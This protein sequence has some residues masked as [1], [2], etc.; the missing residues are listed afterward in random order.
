MNHATKAM[1]DLYGNPLN[2]LVK[3]G[4]RLS[5]SKN[6]LGVRPSNPN[7]QN[8]NQRQQPQPPS[9][10]HQSQVTVSS[11][12]MNFS[13]M[14]DAFQNRAPPSDI[15]IGGNRPILRH[16]DSS[17]AVG[18]TELN[19][20]NHIYSYSISPPPTSRFFSPPPPSSLNAVGSGPGQG[21]SATVNITS[22]S[23]SSASSTSSAS[24]SGAS[25][26]LPGVTG[27]SFSNNMRSTVPS[28]FGGSAL[29]PTLSAQTYSPSFGMNLNA[30]V[31]SPAL[32][33]DD[34]AVRFARSPPI[35]STQIHSFGLS[36]SSL[37]SFSSASS[38]NGAVSPG[39]QMP[40]LSPKK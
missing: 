37:A 1:R 19:S 6:P 28:E 39:L 10:S 7:G 17:L 26:S 9:G 27:S 8:Q 35:S 18:T 3:G 29:S 30:G 16:Y 15:V 33:S 11:N 32:E 5:F 23:M 4:I 34:R 40:S 31:S 12:S 2:G 14:H 36:G 21:V 20:P 22:S 13:S 38:S 25:S 24:A